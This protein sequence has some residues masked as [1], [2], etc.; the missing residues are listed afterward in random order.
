MSV[1]LKLN[2]LC[3]FLYK[4]EYFKANRKLYEIKRFQVLFLTS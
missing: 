3:F 1:V 2:T 4:F